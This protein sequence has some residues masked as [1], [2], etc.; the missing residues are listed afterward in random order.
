MKVDFILVG[1]G[2]AGTLLAFELIRLNKTV[3]IFDDPDHP[4]ASDVAAGLINSVVFRRMTKSWMV[5][6]AFPKLEETYRKLEFL[7][8]EK[9]Y[10]PSEIYRILTKEEASVWNEKAISNKLLDYIDPEPDFSFHHQKIDCPFGIG[11]IT[12]AARL[13][14]SKL[15]QLFSEYLNIN[16][17]IR[18]VK[19][20]FSQLQSNQSG[21]VY[22][23]VSADKI[24]FCEGAAVSQNPFFQELKFK[25]SKGEVLEINI[26]DLKSEATFSRDIFLMPTDKNCFKVGATYSWDN[27]NWQPTDEAREELLDKLKNIFPDSPIII[28]HKSGIRPTMHDRKPVAGFLPDF[29]QIGIFNGLGP[30]GALLGPLFAQKFAELITGASDYLHPEVKIERYLIQK[31]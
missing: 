12:K 23:D 17:A 21:I 16:R 15:I 25:H 31:K 4:K 9:F 11:K 7:L 1:H 3:L 14:I 30:K 29:P 27:L 22:K 18:K 13:D 20:D 26:P 19:F 6:E 28:D 10:Y 8:E 5:D 2:L 24:I